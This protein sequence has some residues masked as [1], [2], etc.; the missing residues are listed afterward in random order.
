M[1]TLEEEQDNIARG[2]AAQ[3]LWRRNNPPVWELREKLDAARRAIDNFL[4]EGKSVTT[5]VLETFLAEEKLK[6]STLE[7]RNE[8]LENVIRELLAEGVVSVMARAK[9]RHALGIE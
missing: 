9:A 4:L 3:E 7:R 6:S 2:K 1:T 5:Q 8:L